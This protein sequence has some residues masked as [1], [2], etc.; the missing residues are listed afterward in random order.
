MTTPDEPWQIS[1]ARRIGREE[2]AAAERARIV[3]WLRERCNNAPM[4]MACSESC[5]IGCDYFA[6]AIEAGEHGE[7][8]NA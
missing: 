7:N 4:C 6:D 8:R 1:E 3:A 5:G 2:G